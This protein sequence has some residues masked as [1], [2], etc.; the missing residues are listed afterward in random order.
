MASMITTEHP[1]PDQ[2]GL[3]RFGLMF[4]VI[5]ALL[6]GLIIP[7]IRF[8]MEGLP[9]LANNQ[10]P[11]WPWWAATVIAALALAVP[12]SL[13]WLYRPWMKFADVAQWVNSRI[14]L[15]IL[16]YLIILPIGLLRRLLRKDSMQ[17][18]FDSKLQS[19]RTELGAA[20]H[21]DMEKP[22]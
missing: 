3:R 4:A 14:I 7:C 5:L 8:G 21:N 20:D 6:F 16:Y 18:K 15:F 2:A 1:I 9:L 12:S 13:K 19:Y 17:R 11:H 10:N 22:Y